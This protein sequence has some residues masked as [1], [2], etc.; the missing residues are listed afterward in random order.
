M[1]ASQYWFAT[2]IYLQVESQI[3]CVV[4]SVNQIPW[5]WY[6]HNYDDWQSEHTPPSDQEGDLL[7]PVNPCPVSYLRI[8]NYDCCNSTTT[9]L[10]TP[11][12]KIEQF[13]STQLTYIGWSLTEPRLE[14]V[15][16]EKLSLKLLASSRWKLRYR[17]WSWCIVGIFSTW[18]DVLIVNIIQLNSYTWCNMNMM[19]ASR[20]P[21]DVSDYTWNC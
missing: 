7:T 3:L 6:Q 20:P 5:G 11:L 10:R 15:L 18:A 4:A 12:I 13:F 16:K 19:P 8:M 14:C 1:S 2:C 21:P 17:T 9:H